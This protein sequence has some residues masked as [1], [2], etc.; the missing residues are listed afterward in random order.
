[1][2][3][4]ISSI[5]FQE[6]Y[7]YGPNYIL[8]YMYKRY[9]YL[10]TILGQFSQTFATHVKHTHQVIAARTKHTVEKLSF[11]N[12]RLQINQQPSR[13]AETIGRLHNYLEINN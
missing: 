2:L 8:F 11:P 10:Y 4:F 3:S 13:I 7:G 9:V 12:A 5:D 1:M 6:N